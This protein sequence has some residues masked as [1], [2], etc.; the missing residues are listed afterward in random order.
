MNDDNAE[1]ATHPFKV[2]DR[3]RYKREIRGSW[4]EATV[5]EITERGFRYEYDEPF[6]LGTRIGSTIGGEAYESSFH[7]WELVPAEAGQRCPECRHMPHPPGECLN[8]AS[9]SDCACT[10]APAPE[11][12][13]E[14]KVLPTVEEMSG[15]VNFGGRVVFREGEQY[16]INPCGKFDP[17]DE[18]S[19]ECECGFL[20]EAHKAEKVVAP[21]VPSE[22]VAD[23]TLHVHFKH[24]GSVEVQGFLQFTRGELKDLGYAVLKV[25]SNRSHDYVPLIRKVNP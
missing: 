12:D 7:W 2:G 16:V 6:V 14:T 9:D 3:V 19:D 25:A 24:D 4:P 10:F 15:S 8:M 17:I 20:K 11:V 1:A 21:T 13:S 22:E 5:T 23:R 18:F